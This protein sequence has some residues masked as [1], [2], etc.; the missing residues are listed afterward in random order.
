MFKFLSKLMSCGSCGTDAPHGDSSKEKEKC[1]ACECPCDEHKEHTHDE[2]KCMACECPCDEHKEHA[3][4]CSK[5]GHAHK[6]DSHCDCGC[7]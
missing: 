1:M 3:H 5:C 2:K 7:A 6:D 4:D